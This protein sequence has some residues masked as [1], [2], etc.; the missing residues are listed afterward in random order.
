MS[1]IKK[2]KEM[3]VGT[4]FTTERKTKYAA[5]LAICQDLR[6]RASAAPVLMLLPSPNYLRTDILF[7]YLYNVP[8][9]LK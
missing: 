3:Y 1:V 2:K 6:V 4:Y 8:Y 7:S 5:F 9:F